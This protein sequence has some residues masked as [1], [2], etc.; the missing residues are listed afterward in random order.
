MK[1]ALA[2]LFMI[3][4]LCSCKMNSEAPLLNGAVAVAPPIVPGVIYSRSLISE[5]VEEIKVSMESQS[6]PAYLI[7]NKDGKFNVVFAYLGG[8]RYLAQKRSQDGEYYYDVY[9][10]SAGTAR[11]V[12]YSSEKLSEFLKKSGIE[13][14]KSTMTDGVIKITGKPSPKKFIAAIRDFVSSNG[15][16]EEKI[17]YWDKSASR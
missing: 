10:I 9:D 13:N 3:I 4:A 8:N 1:S 16:T 17:A 2:C 14:N 6:Y 11:E 12:A 5:E 7:E 15:V